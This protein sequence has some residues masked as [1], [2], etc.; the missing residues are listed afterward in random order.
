MNITNIIGQIDAQIAKLQAAK[1]LL[2]GAVT[3][4]CFRRGVPGVGSF[5]LVTYFFLATASHGVLDAM[6]NGGLGVAF[7]ADAKTATLPQRIG[8]WAATTFSKKLPTSLK[9]GDVWTGTIGGTGMLTTDHQI[10]A[11]LVFG[12]FTNTRTS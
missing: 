1:S 8:S 3:F 6:T 5:A 2:A 11:R 9:P 7:F 10:Y 12:S 4:I